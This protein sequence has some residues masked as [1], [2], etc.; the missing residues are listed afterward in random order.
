MDGQ[1]PYSGLED[2]IYLDDETGF[3]VQESD[4]LDLG[5][6]GDGETIIFYGGSDN[7][8]DDS[9]EGIFI[10]KPE[11]VR[12]LFLLISVMLLTLPC[13]VFIDHIM[14]KGTGGNVV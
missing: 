2:H 6:E 8:A 1:R 7:D 12:S 4:S 3:V 14:C 10:A 11:P 5:E 13:C 9:N